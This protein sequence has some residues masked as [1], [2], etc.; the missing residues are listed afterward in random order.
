MLDTIKTLLLDA[1]PRHLDPQMVD[2]VREWPDTPSALQVLE[3]LDLCV[4]GSLAS[5]MVVMALEIAFT[6]AIKHEGT[7]QEQVV[8]MADTLWRN[9]H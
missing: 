9:L 4:R 2:M 5:P 1:P 3:V 8:A 7:T 6:E